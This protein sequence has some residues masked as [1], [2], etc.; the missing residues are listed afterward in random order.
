MKYILL[1]FLILVSIGAQAGVEDF[2]SI[3]SETSQAERELSQ[4][5]QNQL[6][7]ADLNKVKKPNFRETGEAVLEKGKSENVAVGSYENFNGE[8]KNRKSIELEKKNFKRLSQEF[9]SLKD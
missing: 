6:Q 4:K 7:T 5:L 2:N 3:I 9:K 8:I 1:T